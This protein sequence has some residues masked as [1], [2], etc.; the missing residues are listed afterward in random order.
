[1]ELRVLPLASLLLRESSKVKIALLATFSSPTFSKV[2]DLPRSETMF[3]L[4]GLQ[5]GERQEENGKWGGMGN[6]K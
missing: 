1:M 3:L 6:F 4:W 2:G 5:I